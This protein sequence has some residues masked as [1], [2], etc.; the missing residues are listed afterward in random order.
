MMFTE[1]LPAV[2]I[3]LGNGISTVPVT[4]FTFFILT[5]VYEEAMKLILKEPPRRQSKEQ[6]KVTQSGSIL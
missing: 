3:V 6:W 5:Y 1:V 4:T 2:E